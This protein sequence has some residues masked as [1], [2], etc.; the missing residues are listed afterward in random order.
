M[1]DKLKNFYIAINNANNRWFTFKN[2]LD[3]MK[4]VLGSH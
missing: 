2:K 4:Q 1:N 3:K